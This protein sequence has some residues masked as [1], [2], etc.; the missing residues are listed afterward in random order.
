MSAL[1]IAVAQLKPDE[2]FRAKVYRDIVGKQTIG[3]GFC[4]D[5][6]ISE[7]A[8]AALLAA[9]AAEV[10]S[11]LAKQDWYTLD[12]VR[13]AACICLAFNLGVDGFLGFHDTIQA[14]RS[15]NWQ[16]AHDALLYSKAAQQLPARYG[17]LANW[18]L[19]GSTT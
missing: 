8:A 15:G 7:P 16:G 3:Y 10:E 13:A 11:Y 6:G 18:L 14:L 9:Q 17:R 5:A 12:D 1:D 2:G 4:V 19:T